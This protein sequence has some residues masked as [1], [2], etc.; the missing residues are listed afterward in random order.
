MRDEL[1]DVLG[2]FVQRSHYSAGQLAALSGVPTRTI[3]NWLNGRVRKPH[4]WRGLVDVAAALRLTAVE[5]DLLLQTASHPPLAELR[6]QPIAPADR[7]AL[8]PWPE[9]ADAPFQ[10]IPDLPYF[11]GRDEALADLQT[12]LRDG[13]T[14]SIC[15]LKGMGGV[16]KTA[17]AA[18]LAYELRPFFP[19]GVLWARLDTTDTMTILSD[20]A[21]AYGEDVSERRS[22]ESRSAAVRSLL[23]DKHA[24]I[25][26][27]NAEN[28]G[29][30]RPLLPP[31]V[32]ETAVIITTRHDLAVTDGLHHATV[33]PFDPVRQEALTLFTH[34]LGEQRVQQERNDLCAIAELLGQLPLAL[35]IAAGRLRGMET[36][37][38]H[39]QLEQADKRL[40]ALVREDRSVRLTFDIS[41]M[42][43]SLDLQTF[44][45]ALGTFGGDD[46]GITAVAHVTETDEA[47]AVAYLDELVGLSL[48]Q[49]GR[50]GRYQLHSL[51]RD[52]AQT[53]I[54]SADS[55]QRMVNYFVEYAQQHKGDPIQISSELNNIT[56]SLER[57]LSLHMSQLYVDGVLAM[58]PTWH[59][60]GAFITALPHFQRAVTIS[61]ATKDNY[62][63]AEALA[64]LGNCQWSLGQSEEARHSMKRGLEI[65]YLAED[66]DLI[67]QLLLNL[68][69]IAGYNDGNYQEA[70]QYF[71]EAINYTHSTQRMGLLLSNL[72]NVAYEQGEWDQAAE[73]WQEGL[74][75][76]EERG[77]TDATSYVQLLHNVGVLQ[78]D[79]GNFDDAAIYLQKA[80]RI[81][82]KLNF[83]E[84]I[85]TTL[86]MQGRL[87]YETNQ[88]KQAAIY[89]DEALALGR[90]LQL[91]EAIGLA[92]C[93]LSSLA[94][95]QQDY[96]IT[97]VYLDEARAICA[98]AEISWI[99]V[100][101]LI[102]R[103]ELHLV[104]NLH[105]EACDDFS[106]ALAM[107]EESGALEQQALAL[108]GLAQATA[109][110]NPAQSRQHAEKSYAMLKQMGHYKTVEVDA[111]LA[112]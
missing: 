111:W 103:G 90:K 98:E 27:D 38:Y 20:F 106:K 10:A 102:C 94:T 12:R 71:S 52:Y 110:S 104:Q 107:G 92:L 19:D 91:P 56:S 43:L 64:Y 66:D 35:A 45:A 6:Q 2:R 105:L 44:F 33:L 5:T 4:R 36:A 69:V 84:L 83:A 86:T 57:A 14:V 85:S 77:E 31:T 24:L 101:T 22:I 28:S 95:Q 55:W 13:E 51:L 108:F 18:H 15:N 9:E 80:L 1:M 37:V 89:L 112:G 58:K 75:L 54:P 61:R 78:L 17:L 97:A 16:G 21:A 70:S 8:R 34:L 96:A 46:F 100:D 82:R 49:M 60:H 109:V 11:V 63:Q 76:L 32:G 74:T 88:P 53:H 30:V 47:M 41:Y 87:A 3:R 42:A 67:S 62:Q 68:G 40:D 50:N 72:A 99:T 23:A 7:E 79:R 93:R 81:A 48:V 73:Y 65:A 25:V 39:Q 26:L 59:T 29:Q